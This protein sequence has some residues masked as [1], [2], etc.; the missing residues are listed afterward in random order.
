MTKFLSAAALLALSLAAMPAFAGEYGEGAQGRR[1][2]HESSLADH[3]SND[4]GSNPAFTQGCPPG[5][6]AE[7]FPGP[8][9]RRCAL[10]G[11]GYTY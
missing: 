1:A 4:P 5:A 6:V 2:Q 3:Y 9:G 10:P 8:G 7:P 11:G